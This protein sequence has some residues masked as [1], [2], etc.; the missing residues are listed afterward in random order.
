M[1]RSG[2]EPKRVIETEKTGAKKFYEHPP[3]FHHEIHFSRLREHAFVAKP[4]SLRGLSK[5]LL[6]ARRMRMSVQAHEHNT[7]SSAA[8][9]R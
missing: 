1:Q 3:A 9:K 6:I 5:M 7:A 4:K 2:G 8:T